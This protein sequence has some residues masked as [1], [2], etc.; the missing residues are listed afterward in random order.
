L[1]I[2]FLNQT[3]YPDVASTAQHASDLAAE[4]VEH[5]HQVTVLCSR[6]AYDKPTEVYPQREVW[7]GVRIRRISSLGFGKSARWRR[8]ADF[9]SYLANCMFHLATLPRFDLVIGMTSPPLISWLG[10][11]FT[12]I[13]GGRFLFWVMDLNPDEALAAG[14]LRPNSWTTKILQRMLKY[15]LHQAAIIVALDRFM[16]SRIEEKGIPPTKILVLPPW[17]HDDM[18]QYDIQGRECFRKEHGLVGRYVVMYSGNHSPCHPLATLLEAAQRLGVR[19]DIVFCFIGGGSEFE[20][21]RRFA[22]SH[23][24]SNVVTIPYQ[25]LDKLASSL[26]SA[27]L[28]TVVMGD[29]FVGIVHPCKVYNIRRLGIPYLYIG[30]AESHISDLAPSYSARHGDVDEVVRHLLTSAAASNPKVSPLGPTDH[31][32]QQH[33][34]NKMVLAIEGV[35]SATASVQAKLRAPAAALDR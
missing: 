30:P 7:R 11:L 13:R 5:G 29:P 27:D 6:R 17:P 34:V 18:V 35:V 1:R 25:P 23:D 26:S 14:W 24:L 2:L 22:T 8:A 12:R 4:L 20:T 32:G 28:H 21:V 9:G 15:G 33:L 19:S 16:A 31:H 3:F 10:A